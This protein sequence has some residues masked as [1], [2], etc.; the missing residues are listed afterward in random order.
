MKGQVGW[1]SEQPDLFKDV[2]A[3]CMGVGLD[4]L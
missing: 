3:Y 4:G 2:P 1:R